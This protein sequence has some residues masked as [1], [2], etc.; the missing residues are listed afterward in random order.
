[1]VDYSSP[2]EAVLEIRSITRG[3][4]QYAIDCV[5]KHTAKYAVETLSTTRRTHLVGLTGLPRDVP[6]N[7]QLCTVAS[8]S[9][10]SYPMTSAED[11]L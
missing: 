11:G 7:V 10:A 4:L 9:L 2:E 3:S 6:E 5:G 1:V 8:V